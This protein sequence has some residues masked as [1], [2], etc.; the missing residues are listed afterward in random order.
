MTWFFT[1][2]KTH[3]DDYIARKVKEKAYDVDLKIT[4]TITFK[5]ALFWLF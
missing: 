1:L 3:L 4:F 5:Y 2:K